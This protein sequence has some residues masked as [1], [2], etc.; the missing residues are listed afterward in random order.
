MPYFQSN[1]LLFLFRKI[2]KSHFN[3]L[4][5]P[6]NKKDC[7]LKQTFYINVLLFEYIFC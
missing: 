3:D 7:N 2:K 5:V 4:N 6:V 1:T